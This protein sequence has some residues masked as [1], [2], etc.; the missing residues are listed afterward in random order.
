[1]GRSLMPW[2]R[3]RVRVSDHGPVT[4]VAVAGEIDVGTA[5]GL[6]RRLTAVLDAGRVRL[7]IDLTGVTFCDSTG[8]GVL[9]NA[10]RRLRIQDLRVHLTGLGPV[11]VRLVEV[12]G[13]GP[14]FTIHD[15]LDDAITAATS[16]G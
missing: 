10:A 14:V 15:R 2:Q 6:D 7:V 13:I 8:I 9:V 16:S 12:T 5:A 4:V 3:L 11:M 1:M